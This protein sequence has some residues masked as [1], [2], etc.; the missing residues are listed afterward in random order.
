MCSA[1]RRRSLQPSPDHDIRHRRTGRRGEALVAESQTGQ[2]LLAS[3]AL[4]AEEAG[5]LSP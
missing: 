4:I 2:R 3:A 5:A 1:D